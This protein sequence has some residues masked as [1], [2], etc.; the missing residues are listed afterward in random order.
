MLLLGP[1]NVVKVIEVIEDV[2][3]GKA[4]RIDDEKE[5]TVLAGTDS[6]SKAE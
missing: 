2:V 6:V 1:T 5:R 4:D 3:V